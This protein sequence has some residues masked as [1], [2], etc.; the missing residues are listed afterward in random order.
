MPWS[1]RTR[2]RRPPCCTGSRVTPFDLALGHLI[3]ARRKRKRLTQVVLGKKSGVSQA[4]ISRVES[5]VSPTVAEFAA[6]A[7]A[8]KTSTTK[9][10]ADARQI[11][12]IA[13]KTVRMIHFPNALTPITAADIIPL[14]ASR[15]P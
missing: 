5:G 1:L 12:E 13:H 14:I 2:S 7:V 8:L 3:A 11:V 9:L 4:R 10:W 6:L 15:M